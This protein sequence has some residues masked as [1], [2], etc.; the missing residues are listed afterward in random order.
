MVP[1][2]L[3]LI[4]G[5]SFA[6]YGLQTIFGQRPNAEYDRYGLP[7]LRRF[8]GSMQLLG[9]AGVL[10]GLGYTP[11][12]ALA[13]GGLALMMVLGVIVRVRIQDSPKQMIPAASLAVLNVLLVVAF[14]LA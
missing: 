14:V 5:L 2:T 6:F 9:A 1:I 7:G 8:V 11:L 4:S 3:A 13:A 12:G 10:L